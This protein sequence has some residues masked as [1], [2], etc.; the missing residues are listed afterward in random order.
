M[1]N[2]WV[3]EEEKEQENES[4]QRK[5]KLVLKEGLGRILSI[6]RYSLSTF[7][8][9]STMPGAGNTDSRAGSKH[10]TGGIDRMP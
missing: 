6:Q 8:T 2:R 1:S 5:A 10:L 4:A 3:F 9:P 7:Y